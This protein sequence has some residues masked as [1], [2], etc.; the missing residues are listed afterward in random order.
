MPK[1]IAQKKDWINL[2]HKLFSEQGHAGIVV[3]KLAKKLKCNKSS[4][5][6]HFKTKKDFIQA[7]ID[8]WV[9]IET[10]QIINLTNLEKSAKE[11]FDTLVALAYKKMPHQDFIFF[12]TR[13]A[14]NDKKTK[15]I[16]DKI[17]KQ[18]I[19]YVSTLL[20][21][22]GYSRQE[23]EIKSG[24]FYKHLIGYHEMI[25]YKKQDKDYLH[26]V[27]QELNQFIKY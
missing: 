10:E 11:K 8:H 2:G 22:I 12:L 24:I 16:L 26:E 6:W 25:R 4:F 19:E 5:Y 17:E 13:Y 27:K 15:A 18:R 14:Q 1:I 23:A 21:D 3:E 20:I 9:F 7:L